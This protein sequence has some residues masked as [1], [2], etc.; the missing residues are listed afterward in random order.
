MPEMPKGST[1]HEQEKAM[2]QKGAK[3][4]K[5]SSWQHRPRTYEEPDLEKISIDTKRWRYVLNR[6]LKLH[7]W[8]HSVKDKGVSNRTIAEHAR[9]VHWIFE[10]LRENE[11]KRYKLDPRSLS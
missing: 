2:N 9:F 1:E 11:K 4:G 6:L 7:N 5:G 3:R 10:W 8:R